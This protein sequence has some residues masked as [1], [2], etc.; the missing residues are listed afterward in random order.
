MLAK[1]NC[2]SQLKQMWQIKWI[3]CS[4]AFGG[5]RANKNKKKKHDYPKLNRSPTSPQTK[6]FFLMLFLQQEYPIPRRSV[7]VMPSTLSFSKIFPSFKTL[8]VEVAVASLSFGSRTT[9]TTVKL[10]EY[11]NMSKICATIQRRV[12][13]ATK[14]NT[15]DDRGR[16]NEK[17]FS[18][19]QISAWKFEF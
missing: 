16:I 10:K 7:T 18:S 5:D 12:A 2:F 6:T 4:P 9:N 8:I 19:L 1:L 13:T 17:L 15:S 14:K 11:K 3:P